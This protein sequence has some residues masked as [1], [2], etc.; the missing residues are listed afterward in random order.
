MECF[1]FHE[2]IDQT[3]SLIKK[4]ESLQPEIERVADVCEQALQNG[5]KVV[6]CGNGGSAADAQHLAAELMGRFLM[7]RQPLSSLSLTVDTSALTAI[8][9]DYGFET[10]FA[11]QLRG[12]GRSGDVLVGMSTSGNSKNV[13]KAFE[14]ARELGISTVAMTGRGGGQMAALADIL[15]AV[16]HN[17]TCHIQEAHIT[18]GHMICAMVEEAICSAK[19]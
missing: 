17:R 16:P 13:V 9:N 15:I 6:F 12:I 10:V 1:S 7:D 2:Y 5:N 19:P 8:A 3:I 18:I 4:I 14:C 11:R